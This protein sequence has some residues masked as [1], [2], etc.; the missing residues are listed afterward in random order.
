[1]KQQGF[2][3]FFYTLRAGKLLRYVLSPLSCC[4]KNRTLKGATQRKLEL[5]VVAGYIT[6]IITFTLLSFFSSC[7]QQQDQ[8][9]P[10]KEMFEVL[11]SK[12][13]GLAF[14][15]TLTPSQ[16]FNVFDYMYFYN[17]AGVGAGDFNNDGLI[18]LFFSG[19]QQQNTLY[20][21]K[22][23]L[24]FSDVTAAAHIP[25]DSGWS[26]G[27]SVVDINNDGMLDIY[28]CRVGKYEVLNSRNQF[29]VCTG[30]DANGV[31][32]YADKAAELGLDFSGFSTQAAFFDYDMDGDLDMFLLNHSVHQN[33]TFRP[34]K[35]FLGTYFPLSGDRIYRN[36]GKRFTDVTK[37]TGINSSAIS[38]GL[39]VAVSDID[40]DGYPDLYVGNDFHENDYLYI[41]QHNGTF[42]DVAAQ[43]MMHTSQYS[44]GVDAAD[45]N[46][47]A[48][49]DIISAD[50]LP[51]DP[52]ILKRSLGE[53][54]YDI[55][56]YKIQAGYHYQYTR[57]NLQLNRGNGMFSDIGLYAGVYATDWSWA[58]LWMDMDNDGLKDLFISNGIPKRLNDIDYVN[59]VSDEEVQQK[60]KTNS[61]DEKDMALIEKF[62]QI[63]IP[64]R[65]FRNTG[66]A[67]FADMAAGIKGDRST[68]S[69]GAVYADLDNDGDL[70]IVVSNIDEPVLVYQNKVHETDTAA[71]VQLKLLGP[72]HNRN[73]AGAKVVL[74]TA[75]G[76]QLY[77]KQ[78]VH[79]FQSSMEVPLH[80][81]L[82]KVQV[83]SAFVI[84]PDNT[85]AT[86]QWK[87]GALNE[88]SYTTGLPLFD[89][90]KL[91][92]YYSNPALPM[93]DITSSTGLQYMH[94]ENPFVEF[95]REQ[96]IPHMVSTEGPALAVADINGDSRSDFFIGSSKREKSAVFL[97][98]PDGKFI[99][100]AQPALDRD[101]VYE[102][103]DACWVDVNNDTYPDL[104][105]A[106]G[107][108]EYYGHDEHMQPR[109]YL[110]DGRANL[111]RMEHA[112]DGIFLTASCVA[113]YDFNKDGFI[114]LF[115]GAR[116]VPWEYG[117][118]PQ[119]Y[120]LQNDGTGKFTDVTTQYGKSLADAGFVTQATWQDMD[121][122]GDAD[123][124]VA[125]EWAPLAVWVNSNGKFEKK[126][127]G[128]EK[129]WWNCLVPF[130]ADGDGDMD[131]FA[132]NLGRNSRLHASAKEPVKLYY[133]D[134]DGNGKREQVLTY[135][136]NGKEICFA[137][138]A[139]VEKQ[140]P[141]LKKKFLYAEDFAKASLQDIFGADKLSSSAILSADYMS[142]A[143][144][145]NNGKLQFSMTAAPWQAQLSPIR[146]AT[147]ADANNDTLPD[148]LLAANFYDNNIEM[149]RYDADHGS[150]LINK[151]NGR[152]DY[153]TIN[154]LQV[155]GQVRHIRP[156]NIN[157]RQAYLLARNNDSV[158]V[159][160]RKP[161]LH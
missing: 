148:L 84:W 83:D 32:A 157:G 64:N 130:D 22:G 61:L 161:L 101:N 96:L 128:K 46:N 45:I 2:Y 145:I 129:G 20:L 35:E 24:K 49:P 147:I 154:G 158:K 108:N 54:A 38:Y 57:N 160:A 100:S 155:N 39:G 41:N 140:M 58:T 136:L 11:D 21:N 92:E 95:D 142:S 74:Y 48:W 31:P 7:N 6:T 1:M 4:A 28:V 62:P 40:L 51:S 53:D 135:Y 141:V 114:D 124:L 25:Q 42:T 80:I 8:Q 36:D 105:V 23:G 143:I 59:F 131:L 52:Y 56:Q 47:D 93:T 26:T 104:V 119:S 72:E 115:I 120:L 103:V 113:P 15:N 89:Y 97:Q 79:G 67:T 138:M 116:A 9:A 153:S 10:A 76:I 121:A 99:Q 134:F 109:V 66:N 122:D 55:F 12:Q 151:G 33:G 29:L 132:G 82:H 107:G 91:R 133:N 98:Q 13:T 71:F 16:A 88:I 111:T 152:F 77:E 19:N 156:I 78:A 125:A 81:G 112:F 137:N 69:N 63:K 110:N 75:N 50:M 68:F 34:R 17:G 30:I 139:E 37:Q 126:E 85:Y 27:V 106:S 70:D 60:M 144:L 73:A 14:S 87:T 18:D 149:G 90:S 102:E 117:K 150:I 65:L 127:L 3:D 118:K 159:I 44:M 86:L 123:L 94:K 5:S 146:D 43:R